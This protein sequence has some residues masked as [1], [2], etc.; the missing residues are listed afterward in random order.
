MRKLHTYAN[1]H[2][3]KHNWESW[4]VTGRYIKEKL[5]KSK[6]LVSFKLV[7]GEVLVFVSSVQGK[8]NGTI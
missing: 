5:L 1:E 7:R 4:S 2:D 6:G 3:T 8:S